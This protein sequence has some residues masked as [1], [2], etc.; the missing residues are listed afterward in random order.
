MIE[1]EHPAA[2]KHQ[3]PRTASVIID[4]YNYARFLRIAIDSVL[5]QSRQPIDIIVVDDGST[6]DSADI[7]RSY[8]DRITP[9]FKS[10]GG[11][12]SAFNAGFARA[13]GDV[14]FFL[15]SDDSM[16]PDTVKIV[17]G[18]W[19][20]GVVLVHYLMDVVDADGRMLGVHPPPP[21]TLADG[22]VLADLL[23][24]GRFPT[25]ITSGMAF[26]RA[27][28]EQVMPIS[29][30]TFFQAADGYLVHSVAMLGPVQAIQRSLARQCRHG[31]NDSELGA[32]PR[33]LAESFRKKVVYIRNELATV[34]DMAHRLG[35]TVAENIGE[36]DATYLAFRLF[37]LKLD[38]RSHPLPHDKKGELL[39]RYF[40][41][42]SA[43][44]EPGGRRI[45]E[46]VLAA[47]I[48]VLPRR[49]A[50]VLLRWRYVP[51]ARPAWLRYLW[52]RYKA[53]AI[54]GGR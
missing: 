39:I 5:A 22:H 14:V 23:T 19:R 11:Q 4:N 46:L 49:A 9:I 53:L 12:A 2:S 54:H 35:L 33:G 17:L 10:N 27:A 50:L 18:A 25:T 26:A 7:I 42:K 51:N 44:R 36:D 47:A 15:D 21:H 32:D 48:A 43:A 41:A 37:S 52:L 29:V 34:R 1:L 40:R 38:C 8:G 3:L 45:A 30:Q 13:R 31:Q 24:K 20:C 6:D 16:Y 28:L